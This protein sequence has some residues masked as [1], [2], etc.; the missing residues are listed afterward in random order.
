MP[1]IQI[2]ISRDEK[3][4]DHLCTPI[5]CCGTG[6][7]LSTV[8]GSAG[9]MIPPHFECEQVHSAKPDPAQGTNFPRPSRVPPRVVAR[10]FP[11]HIR[12]EQAVISHLPLRLRIWSEFERRLQ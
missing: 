2:H 4:M 6:H 11:W 3:H 7:A 1:T 10:S 8:A 5:H 9:G 12:S